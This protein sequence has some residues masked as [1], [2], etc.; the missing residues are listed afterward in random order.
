MPRITRTS[1]KELRLNLASV[2]RKASKG[3]PTVVTF[4]GK[5]RALVIPA[6]SRF[7]KALLAKKAGPK[8]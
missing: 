1:V 4:H 2:L 7:A 6:D 8:K 3:T 5:P